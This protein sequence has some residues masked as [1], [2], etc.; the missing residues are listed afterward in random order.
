M[1]LCNFYVVVFLRQLFGAPFFKTNHKH[2]EADDDNL[3]LLLLLLRAAFFFSSSLA[4]S[5]SPS[6]SL[7]PDSSL[8]CFLLFSFASFTHSNCHSSCCD[9]ATPTAR[10]VAEKIALFLRLNENWI[11]MGF[12]ERF[13]CYPSCFSSVFSETVRTFF[14]LSKETSR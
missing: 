12:V 8:N 6:R 2:H 13:L 9:F 7:Q 1:C 10:K 11:E 5:L 14:F 3:L 4:R